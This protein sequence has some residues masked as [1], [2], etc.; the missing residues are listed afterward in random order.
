MDFNTGSYTKKGVFPFGNVFPRERLSSLFR[1]NLFGQ[2][3]ARFI[4]KKVERKYGK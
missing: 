3:E 2:K 4:D 1:Q